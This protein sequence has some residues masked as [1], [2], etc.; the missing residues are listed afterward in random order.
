MDIV[1]ERFRRTL[2]P[3][4]E[5]PVSGGSLKNEP[6]LPS[7][8]WLPPSGYSGIEVPRTVLA[9]GADLTVGGVFRAIWQALTAASTGFTQGLFSAPGTLRQGRFTDT[10][11]PERPGSN[12]D[13]R[14]IQLT[15]VS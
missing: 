7:F 10:S 14:S 13:T 3:P 1:S 5:I 12:R 6:R 11:P 4:I 8:P 9:L 2:G 15:R